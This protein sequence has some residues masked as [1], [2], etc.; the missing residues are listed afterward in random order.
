M[1]PVL[2]QVIAYNIAM[3]GTME[4]NKYISAQRTADED[5]QV[6]LEEAKRNKEVQQLQDHTP[7]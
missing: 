2:H 6:K 4:A 7:V 5:E 1:E 3:Q